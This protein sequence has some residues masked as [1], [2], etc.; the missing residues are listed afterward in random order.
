[1]TVGLQVE[2]QGI[3]SVEA[4]LGRAP[5]NRTS[6]A[7]D[8]RPARSAARAILLDCLTVARRYR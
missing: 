7:A 8:Y 4:E 2:V 5:D 6:G 3:A 1:M